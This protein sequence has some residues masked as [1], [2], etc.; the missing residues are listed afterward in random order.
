VSA[1]LHALGKKRNPPSSK[2]EQQHS[3]VVFGAVE[4]FIRSQAALY[5]LRWNDCHNYK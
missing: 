4:I 3:F 1:Q 5:I 2:A